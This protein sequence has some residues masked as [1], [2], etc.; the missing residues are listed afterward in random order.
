MN[1]P[2]LQYIFKGVLAIICI[3]FLSMNILFVTAPIAKFLI[4]ENAE[5]S[6][7]G[8]FIKAPF[9]LCLGLSFWHITYKMGKFQNFITLLFYVGII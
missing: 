7:L 3:A 1:I 5:H 4:P 9:L 2:G 6:A 8:M